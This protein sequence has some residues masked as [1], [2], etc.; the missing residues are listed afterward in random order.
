MFA[1]RKKLQ[2]LLLQF[3]WLKQQPHVCLAHAA[4]LDL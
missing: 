3:F 4:V 1:L 2:L